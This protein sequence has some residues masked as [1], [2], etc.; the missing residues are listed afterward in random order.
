MRK[1]PFGVYYALNCVYRKTKGWSSQFFSVVSVLYIDQ[2][3]SN[4]K[5][6]KNI[7]I[8]MLFQFESN[9]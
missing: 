2:Q 4:P 7:S 3:K 1:N 9:L 5:N 8:V 6:A